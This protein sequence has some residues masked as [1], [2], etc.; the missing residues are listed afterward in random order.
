MAGQVG[1]ERVCAWGVCGRLVEGGR[2]G[3]PMDILYSGVELGREHPMSAAAHL[4]GHL[5]YTPQGLLISRRARSIIY[6]ELRPSQG[7]RP[8]RYYTAGSI[9]LRGAR[10]IV[11]IR[12]C[13]LAH[14]LLTS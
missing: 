14:A 5:L 4:R 7:G 6:P 2:W 1:V 10:C 11:S 8:K 13:L 3:G 9:Y 12:W